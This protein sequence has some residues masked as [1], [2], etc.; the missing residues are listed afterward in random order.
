MEKLNY[1]AIVETDF[2]NSEQLDYIELGKEDTCEPSCKKSC[3]PSNHDGSSSV[4]V[5]D[6][7]I[8]SAQ[9]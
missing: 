7:L 3:A 9:V 4:K 2:L 5:N 6:Q 1:Q 8:S